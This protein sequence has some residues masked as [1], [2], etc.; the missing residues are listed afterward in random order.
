MYSFINLQNYV[1]Y[2]II[3][4]VFIRRGMFFIKILQLGLGSTRLKDVDKQF[5]AQDILLRSGQIMQYGTGN[6]AY[7]KVTSI[8]KR[9]V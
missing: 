8:T 7:N 1:K 5:I 2:D 3:F 9:N 4:L 6:Y